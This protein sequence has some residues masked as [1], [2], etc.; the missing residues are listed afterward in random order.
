MNRILITGANGL[1]GQK[2]VQMLA[3][4]SGC[5]V[6]AS[7]R[8]SCRIEKLP[9]NAQYE[10]CDI[11]L[12][13][14]IEELCLRLRPDV[15]IHTAA[16]TNVDECELNPET[17]RIQNVEATRNVI[18]ASEKVQAHLIHLSTDF[19]FDGE[20]G[21]Y[22]EEDQANPISVYGHSKL[23]AEKLVMQASCPWSIVRT[24]LVYG[25]APG[26]S[27]SNIILWVK[28]SLEQGKSIQVV[29]DQFRT[30]T[31]AEDLAQGC[32]LIAQKK[33]TGIFNI[34]GKELMTPFEMAMQTADYFRL[35]KLLIQRATAATFSQPAR[36]PPRTGFHIEKAERELG[37]HP[38]SF[39]EGIRMLESQLGNA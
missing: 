2:L 38:H 19:I 37:Y 25:I 12:A 8:G 31:L 35:D 13:V 7:S 27:R 21:P 5:T 6:A 29:D 22:S 16:M 10:S 15:I 4:F 20:K 32:L 9:K 23:E 34:S 30:P 26:L 18:R 33:A 36:R 3:A 28:A 14:S 11:T 24:V 17:C 39:P 1:L